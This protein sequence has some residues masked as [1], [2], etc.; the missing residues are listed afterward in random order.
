M[1]NHQNAPQ[2]YVPGRYK[3]DDYGKGGFRFADMSHQG[4]ILASPTGIRSIDLINFSQI[5]DAIIDLALNSAE[6]LDLL[7][8]GTGPS[9]MPMPTKL[10]A[11]L[12]NAGVGCETMATHVA[13]RTYNMLTDEGRRVGALLIA[14]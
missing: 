2:G 4:S 11:K 9:L 10:R 3:I 7:I 12:R 8:I 6:A 1:D 13:V 14:V 5:D